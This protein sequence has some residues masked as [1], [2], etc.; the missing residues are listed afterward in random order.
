MNRKISIG[1]TISLI[2]IACAV[3]FVVTMTASLNAY[4]N[5]IADVQQREEIYTRMQEI[6]SFIKSYSIY[7]TDDS[8][9]K[10]G[11][12][13]GYLGSVNDSY[14]KYYSTSEYYYKTQ[15]ESGR[16]I[17]LG[18]V[19]SKEEGG[20]IRV[21]K[22]YEGSPAAQNGISAGDII[23]AVGGVNVLESGYDA[24]AQQIQYGDE[25]TKQR[26]TIR[27]NGEETEYNMTRMSFAISSVNGVLLDNGILYLGFND[28][29]N[30][31]GEIVDKILSD[32][33]DNSVT[34]YIFDLRNVSSGI[35]G[36]LSQILGHFMDGREVASAVYRN[37]ST[38]TIVETEGGGFTNL[39]ISIIINEKTGGSAEV[40]AITLRDYAE[41]KTVGAVTKGYGTLQETKSF[42]DGSAIEISVAVVRPS[43][44]SSYFNNTG[45]KPEF[46][47]D[48]SE[49][50][51]SSPEYYAQSPDLQLKKAIEVIISKVE[52]AAEETLTVNE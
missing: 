13:S 4:N 9:I 16:M 36:S 48:Y 2:A 10:A 21:S 29:N 46:A 45:V 17:G 23:S 33:A 5:K 11:V 1:I 44:D 52:A 6:D 7:E 50:P 15:V 30:S 43:N 20:Y 47:V 31:T 27:R 51:E 26:F 38:K 32:N 19:P 14:A 24:A 40:L 28:I 8:A 42:S 37:N 35:Y 22:V 25:G 34:G 41:A 3:T 39:P 18:I 49:N 12:Y